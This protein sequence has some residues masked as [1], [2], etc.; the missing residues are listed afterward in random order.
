MRPKINQKELF[1][2]V[3]KKREHILDAEKGINDSE[4]VRRDA[5]TY[6]DVKLGILRKYL[7]SYL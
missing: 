5:R 6:T 7:Y 4:L 1:E 2:R 3:K